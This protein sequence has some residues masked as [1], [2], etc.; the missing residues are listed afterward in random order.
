MYLE[1]I[2]DYHT[3][4]YT[5]IISYYQYKNKLHP[6]NQRKIYLGIMFK[7]L[8]ACKGHNWFNHKENLIFTKTVVDH[9]N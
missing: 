7:K 4:T 6:R 9:H 5:L 8:H 3:Y 2:G 1:T